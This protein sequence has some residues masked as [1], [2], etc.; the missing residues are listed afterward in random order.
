MVTL[1]FIESLTLIE[2]LI[3][4]F[5]GSNFTI[6]GAFMV[7]CGVRKFSAASPKN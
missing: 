2:M 1:S 3:F 5:I 4:G 7:Q 6:A